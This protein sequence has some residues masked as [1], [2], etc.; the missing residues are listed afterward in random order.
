M[1]INLQN[2]QSG[3]ALISAI[4]VV[5]LAASVSFAL[6]ERQLLDIHRTSN[7]LQSDR[8]FIYGHGGG[9]WAKGMLL[10]DIEDDKKEKEPYD[11]LDEEWAKPLP[12]TPFEGGEIA[13]VIEDMQSRFNLNNLYLKKDA[14]PDT[15]EQVKQQLTL[16]IRLLRTLGIDEQLAQKIGDWLDEDINTRFP[17]G[18]EDL[19]YLAETPPYRTANSRMGSPT[20]LRLILGM[21]QEIYEKLIP[22]VTVLP[23]STNLNVN[24]ISAELLMALDDKI[25]ESQAQTLAEERKESPFTSKNDFLDRLEKLISDNTELDRASIES[26]IDISSRYYMSR[27]TIKLENFKQET[28]SLIKKTDSNQTLVVSRSYGVY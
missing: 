24:T 21:T 4:L 15:Q 10:R 6:M 20:E 2:R 1:N 28:F 9:E 23:E 11:G 17:D 27:T 12:P 3:V 13:A 25:E 19:E 18:A 8:S 16:F 7:V 22:H 5:A 14:D 26:K